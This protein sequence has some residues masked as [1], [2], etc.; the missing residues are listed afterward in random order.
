MSNKLVSWS[1]EKCCRLHHQ[2]SMSPSYPAV[3]K[4]AEARLLL[5]ASCLFLCYHSLVGG[6]DLRRP[7]IW[8]SIVGRFRHRLLRVFLTPRLPVPTRT[9]QAP[10][11]RLCQ[12]TLPLVLSSCPW[13]LTTCRTD[14]QSRFWFW[15]GVAHPDSLL[16]IFSSKIVFRPAAP[17][18]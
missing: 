3:S 15:S 5:P 12:P 1:S 9:V 16:S 6:L 7:M 2:K 18:S 10:R 4:Q 8:Q 13:C 14:H 11:G 17:S